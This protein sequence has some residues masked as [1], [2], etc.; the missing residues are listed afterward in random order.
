MI[1]EFTREEVVRLALDAG[2][3]RHEVMNGITKFERLMRVA[4]KEVNK[5][6]NKEEDFDMDGRC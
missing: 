1:E 4:V 5:E 2:F 6:V 3:S